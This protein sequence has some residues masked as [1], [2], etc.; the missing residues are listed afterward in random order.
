MPDCLSYLLPC[1]PCPLCLAA[2]DYATN[3]TTNNTT[4]NATNDHAEEDPLLG[5]GRRITLAIQPIRRRKM[6]MMMIFTSAGAERLA[7]D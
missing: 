6:G 2:A 5:F 1:P 3:N 4:N 7:R